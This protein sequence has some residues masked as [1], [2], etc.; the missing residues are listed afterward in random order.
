MNAE[1]IIGSHGTSV[2]AVLRYPTIVVIAESIPN[3]SV[4]T[5]G[6]NEKTAEITVVK[7]KIA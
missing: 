1:K 6:R 4:V 3:G 7:N 5:T 2:F